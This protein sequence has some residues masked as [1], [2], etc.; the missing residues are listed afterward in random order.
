MLQKSVENKPLIGAMLMDFGHC[1]LHSKCMNLSGTSISNQS[2]NSVL[3]CL[4]Q[5]RHTA[6]GVLFY[7]T[8]RGS[9]TAYRTQNYPQCLEYRQ[10]DKNSKKIGAVCNYQC[11]SGNNYVE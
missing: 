2:L 4:S 5:H 9:N 11:D 3:L 1:W 7:M 6:N 10:S 8:N